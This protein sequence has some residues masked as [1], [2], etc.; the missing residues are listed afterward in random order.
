MF[1][2]VMT[3]LVLEATVV[4]I[5]AFICSICSAN[6]SGFMG[7]NPSRENGDFCQ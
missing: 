1:I 2:H 4:L 6:I 3:M 5:T 7:A